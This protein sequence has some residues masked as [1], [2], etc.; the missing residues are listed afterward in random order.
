MPLVPGFQLEILLQVHLPT[1]ILDPP[2][3]SFSAAMVP[4]VSGQVGQGV[5][6]QHK[7]YLQK[8]CLKTD[9]AA[10][11]TSDRDCLWQ[12]VPCE[13]GSNA[14]IPRDCVG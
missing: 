12:G 2:D 11:L 6:P 8:M 1:H 13:G 9:T 14:P 3:P 10:S 7:Q 4:L 5:E